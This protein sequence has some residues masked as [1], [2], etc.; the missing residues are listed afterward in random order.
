MKKFTFAPIA[1]F[2]LTMIL[3]GCSSN[4]PEPK[5]LPNGLELGPRCEAYCNERLEKNPYSTDI[6]A[7]Q[8]SCEVQA[9]RNSF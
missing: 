9:E 8:L 7:C 3:A 4:K 6:E 2:T 5:I 1:I